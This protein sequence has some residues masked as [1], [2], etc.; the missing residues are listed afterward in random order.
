MSTDER[1][2]VVAFDASDESQAAVRAAATLFPGRL[3]LVVS[4]W[5]PGL[6][7]ALTPPTDTISG[8]AYA[9]P[10]PETMAKVD[11]TQHEHA[12]DTAAAGA[13]L[14]SELGA[15]VEPLAAAEERDVAETI[16]GVA[17][18]RD[19]AAVVVGSRGLG[20]IKSRLLGSTSQ[21]V[22]HHTTRPVV[23]VRAPS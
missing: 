14:A 6:A 20:R 19:A 11:R 13:R 5:E 22:L 3:L 2:V 16:V 8:I 9:G 12:A 1:P 17:E 15:E 21:G 23:V 10:D 18:R 4:V 7:L